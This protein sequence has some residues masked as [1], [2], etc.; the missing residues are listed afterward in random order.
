MTDT[1]VDTNTRYAEV[2]DVEDH[3]RNQSFDGSSE[4]TKSRVQSLLDKASEKIDRMTNRAWR[5]RKVEDSPSRVEFDSAI[6]SQ[7]RRNFRRSSKHGLVQNTSY[8]GKVF[9]PHMEVQNID[10]NQGDKIV[11][12]QPQ[13]TNDITADGGSRDNSQW[14]LNNR[15]GV[16]EVD[17]SQFIRGPI[18]A[19]G[20]TLVRD[21][22]VELTYRYGDDSALT[23]S[24][25]DD[26]PADI[27][28]ACAKMVASDLME[29]DTFG[30]VLPSTENI[31]PQDA[32]ER[33]Q[34]EAEDIIAHYRYDPK[35][36]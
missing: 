8:W 32:A 18:G 34:T 15:D 3:V 12:L 5:V 19:N 24:V 14:Y 21:A 26:L 25:P 10:S 30:E 23:N 33:L 20:S 29:T 22:R 35:V 6:E 11:V 7:F 17:V 1:L 13:G 28:E 27:S 16:L 36:L 31:D 4:P 9:L 2:V